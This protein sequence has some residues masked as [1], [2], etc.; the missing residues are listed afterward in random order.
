MFV[1]LTLGVATSLFQ[2]S[3]LVLKG[4]SPVSEAL[5]IDK[6]KNYTSLKTKLDNPLF[7]PSSD[8]P[9]DQSY[10]NLEETGKDTFDSP[11]F[12]VIAPAGSGKTK[13]IVDLALIKCE[14]VIYIDC[15]TLM[16]FFGK[17]K[18]KISNE[19][20]FPAGIRFM[21]ELLQK[22]LYC[23]ALLVTES[24]VKSAEEF[25]KYWAGLDS[26][27]L[28]WILDAVIPAD[29]HCTK[30][31]IFAFD[32]FQELLGS[33][34][35]VI[36]N[37]KSCTIDHEQ[38]LSHSSLCALLIHSRSSFKRIRFIFNGTSLRLSRL[39]QDDSPLRKN[40]HK[41]LRPP[42][43]DE[44]VVRKYLIMNHVDEKVANMAASHL[45]GRPLASQYFVDVYKEEEKSIANC[46]TVSNSPRA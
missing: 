35:G 4:K 38:S 29:R 9:L 46:S 16:N 33:F 18:G 43:F 5:W 28:M 15:K 45:I 23:S 7:F 17:V 36:Q 11:T 19:K 25:F 30:S 2:I 26:Y 31:F 21:E 14:Y 20:S 39:V 44:Q 22:F 32:E 12:F 8:L 40:L 34:D 41:I 3:E 13:F 42:F 1:G 24:I 27:H 6:L 37:L 10:L